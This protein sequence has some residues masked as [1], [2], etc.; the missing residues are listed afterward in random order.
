MPQ[1]QGVQNLQTVVSQG[2]GWA[3]KEVKSKSK[4]LK[5]VMWP[6]TGFSIIMKKLWLE[7]EIQKKVIFQ[8]P[9]HPKPRCAKPSHGSVRRGVRRLGLG[10]KKSQ[11]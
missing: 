10:E 5:K 7:R 9:L 8:L 2:L 4:V 1:E 6:T 3:K 11:K